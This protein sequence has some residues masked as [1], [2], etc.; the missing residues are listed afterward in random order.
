MKYNFSKY[1]LFTGVLAITGMAGCK[2][3]TEEYNPASRT[4]ET[5]YNTPDGFE[6]LVKSNYPELRA[7]VGSGNLYFV[8]TD[9]FSSMGI[10]DNYGNNLYNNTFNSFNGDVDAYFRRL[11]VSIN[12]ANNTIYWATQVAGGNP[13][14]L[15]IRVA[16]AKALRAYYY[17]LLTETFGDV[18]S[19]TYPYYCGNP[20]LTPVHLKRKFTTRSSWTLQNLLLH[21][22]QLLLILAVLQKVL[23][24]IYWQKCI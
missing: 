5:Y 15:A 21:Y 1:L 24:S 3:Y 8:G 13:A 19:G 4:A 2:K 6:D 22:R 11:Y 20:V 17:F 18:P 16:E 7:I 9:A 12:I 14:T 10:N 23:H